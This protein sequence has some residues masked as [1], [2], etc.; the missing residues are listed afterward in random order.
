[1]TTAVQPELLPASPPHEVQRSISWQQA[2]A[3]EPAVLAA[4]LL[5]LGVYYLVPG[6]ATALVGGLAFFALTVY[7]PDLSLAMVPLAT[8]LFYRP[9]YIGNLYFSLAEFVIVCGAGAFALRAA[10]S[11]VRHKR[12]RGVVPLLRDRSVWLALALVLIAVAWLF[13]PEPQR[14]NLA[15]REFRATI[16]EPV[17]FFGLMLYNLRTERDLWRMT[18][19][20]LIAAALVGREGVEQFLFGQTWSMEGVGRV[21][22]VYPSAT[23]FGIYIGRALPLAIVLAFFLPARWK[24]WR[25]ACA[26]LAIVIGLG[27]LFSFARGAWIGVFAGLVVVAIMTRDRRLVI[28]LAAAL[29][30]GLALLPF[31]RV[32][33]IT[34]MF[35]FASEDN[36]GLSRL[37]IWTSALRVLRDHPFTG[38]GEDQFLYQDAAKYGIPQLRFLTVSHPHNFLLDFWLRLGVPGLAWVL[39]ALTYF[40]WQGY[41]LWKRYAGTALGALALGLIASMVDFAVHGLLDM[42]YFTMDLALTFWLTF[43]LMVIMG[44]LR[45][46]T[47]ADFKP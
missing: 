38:I 29:L 12:L 26:L 47:T 20:W 45:P 11:L 9:R 24:L 27:A 32:E 15:L 34:S 31:I 17:I 21:T 6:L 30:A 8:P 41:M 5:A 35:D 10:W 22:S 33:R 23:A 7:R 40:F 13:V 16:L 43:G 1:M 18:A 2:L 25:I 42:A 4:M 44:R 46:D 28:A 39:A 36:T 19:A 3:S 37:K 14:R